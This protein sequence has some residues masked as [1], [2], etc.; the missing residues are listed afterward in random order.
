MSEEFYELLNSAAA[1]DFP[2]SKGATL[3]D[4][5]DQHISPAGKSE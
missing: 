2:F 1:T 5:G 3:H 4:P